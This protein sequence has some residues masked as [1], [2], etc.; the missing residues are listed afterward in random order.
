LYTQCAKC[1]TVF[2]LSAEVLRAA[3]GQVRCG[4][5]GEVFNALARLAEDASA[6]PAGESALELEARAD[7]ILQSTVPPVHTTAPA[8]EDFE[9]V[10]AADV[11]LAR[12]EVLDALHDD[13]T[14]DAP[15]KPEPA[16]PPRGGDSDKAAAAAKAAAALK[17]AAAARAAAALKAGASKPSP[18]GARSGAGD[19]V[20]PGDLAKPG[21]GV[22]SESAA[23]PGD[24][25]KPA[26]R[27]RLEG[28]AQSADATGSADAGKPASPAPAAPASADEQE[29]SSLEFTLP[30][31]ELD[32]IFVEAAPRPAESAAP[33]AP[34]ESNEPIHGEGAPARMA[35][36][37]IPEA[38]R[39]EM[40]EGMKAEPLLPQIQRPALGLL[41]FALW[42]GAAL[43]L[44]LLL[45][46]QTIHE[47][48]G[49]LA[50]HAPGP[51]HGLYAALG[52]AL[53]AAA[54]LSVYQLR[55][56][57]VT[58]DPSASGML[59]VRASILNTSP[60]LQPY[61][62][63]R[64]TLA[65][66]FGARIGTRD[67]EPAEYMGKPIVRMLAPGERADVT[68]DIVDPGKDS[69]GKD[70]EGFEFD[71]CLR[72]IEQ[73]ISC[74]ADAAAQPSAAQPSAAQPSAAQPSA[75]QPS[76]AQPG[77]AQPNAAQPNAAQPGTA[78]PSQ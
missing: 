8:G 34:A 14:K 49:W 70:A 47:N 54:T 71:L 5:C 43:V 21:G 58:G 74:A 53:P 12:L 59:R 50:A 33:A 41:P 19:V 9:D 22:R 60:Q 62:L 2:R 3:G 45:G 20:R 78:K 68:F 26:E 30:P 29:D 15:E 64:V 28:A 51:L 17:L 61:P 13:D 65:D 38:V 46:A 69:P 55:Q 44:A 73:N 40:L 66:R 1:E 57:G 25:A 56:W 48:R 77:A 39:R 67:F 36:P 32:R 16:P 42:L 11:E 52:V 6:F 27:R 35:G 63:L 10:D 76:A 18:P 72:N 7:E 75:A 37:E 24:L 23:G 4:R 31:H